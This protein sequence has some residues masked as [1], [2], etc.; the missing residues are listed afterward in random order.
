MYS[1]VIIELEQIFCNNKL[2]ISQLVKPV[3]R[4]HPWDKVKVAL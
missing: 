1:T 3:L 4:G 2:F